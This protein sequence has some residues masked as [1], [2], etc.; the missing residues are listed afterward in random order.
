[1]MPKVSIMM[2]CYNAEAYVGEAINSIIKQTYRDWELIIIDDGSTDNS[3][4]ICS[5]YQ[6]QDNRIKILVNEKNMGLVYTRNKMLDVANGEYLAIM[7][8]DD[9][10][11]ENRIEL[12]VAFLEKHPDVGGVSSGCYIVDENSNIISEMV[13]PGRTPEEVKAWLLFDNIIINSSAMFRKEVIAEF[14]I[15]YQDNQTVMQDYGLWTS[16]VTNS[17]WV[18]MEEKLV[19]YRDF[20][21][22]IS[23][24]MNK[25]DIASNIERSIRENYLKKL[26][27][28]LKGRNLEWYITGVS[29]FQKKTTGTKFR[30]LCSIL[31]LAPQTG[32][33]W[34]AALICGLKFVK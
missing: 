32:K 28:A 21:N 22:N 27:V 1:M 13:M 24:K 2:A 20:Q 30:L 34:R 8:A 10:S 29:K 18:V 25:K 9:I 3:C 31:A 17:N 12:Q 14:G 33:M 7:D 6:S 16:F 5:Q 4:A 11:F 19:K 23:H 26:G 15:A